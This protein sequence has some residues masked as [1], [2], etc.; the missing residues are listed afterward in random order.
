VQ[1]LNAADMRQQQQTSATTTVGLPPRPVRMTAMSGG[2]PAGGAAPRASWG[3]AAPT[4]RGSGAIRAPGAG[5]GGGGF[6]QERGGGWS[7]QPVA[8]RGQAGAPL[9]APVPAL[10]GLVGRDLVL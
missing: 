9:G 10:E 5:E 8:A 3:P 4:S 7:R 1:E 6:D 2:R